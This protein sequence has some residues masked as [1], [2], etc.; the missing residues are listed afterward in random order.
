M[1][2]DTDRGENQAK[3]P[4]GDKKNIIYNFIITI[5]SAIVLLVESLFIL[6][7]AFRKGFLKKEIL[8]KKSDIGFDIIIKSN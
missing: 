4:I 2:G 5:L 8:T 1:I 7:S 6:L 3:T